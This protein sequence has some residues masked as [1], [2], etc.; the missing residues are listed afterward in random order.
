[1]NFIVK[2]GNN[3]HQS[4]VGN[5]K[6]PL[7]GSK[8]SGC[9]QK[10]YTRSSIPTSNAQGPHR[11]VSKN[12]RAQNGPPHGP[13]RSKWKQRRGDRL[14][15]FFSSRDFLRGQFHATIQTTGSTGSDLDDP[16]H[17]DAW[18]WTPEHVGGEY[19]RLRWMREVLTK[20]APPPFF[21]QATL[22][23][24][25]TAVSN[26]LGACATWKNKG[27]VGEMWHVTA[28]IT[29]S[30]CGLEQIIT[31][32]S[33]DMRQTKKNRNKLQSGL[34]VLFLWEKKYKA[35]H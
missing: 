24:H 21:G 15:R 5:P 20:C 4:D 17:V 2:Q 27:E 30:V 18:M 11:A 25:V 22:L 31:L 35:R 14:H 7:R 26:H 16:L 28:R 29:P 32:Q 6:C 10:T 33:K 8:I 3:Y 12:W 9:R 23:G 1:M 34:E 13:G 19:R